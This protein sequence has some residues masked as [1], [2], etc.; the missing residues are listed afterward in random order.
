LSQIAFSYGKFGKEIIEEIE[1]R[2][3]DYSVW[4]QNNLLKGELF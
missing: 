1:R 4:Q 3:V 2:N